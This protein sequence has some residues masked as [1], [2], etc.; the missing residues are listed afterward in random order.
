MLEVE[1]CES[2]GNDLSS[3]QTVSMKADRL[4]DTSLWAAQVSLLIIWE[5]FVWAELAM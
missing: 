4:Q 5:T 1:N 2:L 3:V